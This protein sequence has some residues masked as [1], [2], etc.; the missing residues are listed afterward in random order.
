[1]SLDLTGLGSVFDFGSKIIDKIFPDPVQKAQATL[2]LTKLQ[3]SGELAQLAAETDL[4][5]GQQAVNLEEAKSESV[6]KSG[7]R[8]FVGW[9]CGTGL[10]MQFLVAPVATFFASAVGHPL[11]FPALDLS[12]LLTLLFGM[13]GMGTLRSFDKKQSSK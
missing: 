13:L 4:L 10:A 3:Q 12:T 9:I 6:F 8:P 2:E 11:V 1:M 5:K 7:W